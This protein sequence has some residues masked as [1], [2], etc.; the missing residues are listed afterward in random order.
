M[1]GGGRDG[2]DRAKSQG[3]TCVLKLWAVL[4]SLILYQ[5]YVEVFLSWFPFYYWA[6][7]VLLIALLTPKTNV[8]SLAFEAVVVPLV[9][10]AEVA[11]DS[12]VKPALVQLAARH[13]HWLHCA[14]MQVAL[15]SLADAELEKLA[16]ELQR[17]LADIEALQQARA[18]ATDD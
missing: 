5:Q 3:H 12:R 11:F 4:G 14:A 1:A 17:R 18:D 8:P 15:P 2:A 13:G 10:A 16:T 9:E 6:K 7:C